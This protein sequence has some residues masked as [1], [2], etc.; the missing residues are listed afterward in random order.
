MQP[1][2]HVTYLDGLTSGYQRA[3]VVFTALRAGVF[4]H[5]KHPI[6]AEALAHALGWS[7]RGTRML[8]DALLA[9]GVVSKHNGQ[10]R[11]GPVAEQC[12]IAGAPED[13]RHI[14]LHK[15]NGY[16]RWARLEEAVR[17]GTAPPRAQ[18]QR[19]PEE[20]RAFIC[21]MADI[22]RI[23]AQQLLAAVDLSGHRFLLD[24]GTGPGTYAVTLLQRYPRM[25]ALLF[26]LPEVLP[27][28]REQVH[29][30]DLAPRV[31][32]VAGD[33][34]RDEFPPGYDLVLLSNIIH[35]F[36]PVVNR[37]LVRRCFTGMASGGRLIIKDFLV[38]PQR[39]GPPFSLMFA[40]QM[41]LNTDGGD[42]YSTADVEAWTN[43]AGF[44][45][46]EFRDLTEQTRLWIVR[47][48]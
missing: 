7:P 15:A 4:E 39:S 27:I 29:K 9:V 19:S 44:V 41:L 22:A 40:L 18:P 47:K 25:R 26:D 32:F 38:D 28:T 43:A 1:S 2:E 35:S 10:Y 17:T 16:E 24:L 6:P 11:N 14:L 33:M 34:T 31:E 21:G 20:L 45:E 46:G 3:Q 36:G 12:L 23:S 37:D 48:P 5:L 30:A 13:Q 8:L 42:V